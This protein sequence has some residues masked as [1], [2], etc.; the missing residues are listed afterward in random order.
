MKETHSE[1]LAPAGDLESFYAAIQYGADAV[2]LGGTAFGMRTSAA[3]FSFPTL[4]KAI[5][6]A[7]SKGVRVY[8]TCNIVPTNREAEQFPAF[9][10]SAVEA[11]ID[12]C[13]LSDLGLLLQAK[14][15]FPKLEL[16]ASTQVGIMNYQTANALYEL[17]V[18]RV[19]LARELSLDDIRFIREHTPSELELEVF[20][21][22]AMCMSV[23][24]RCLISQYLMHRDANRGACAQP[25]RWGYHLMEE[26][27][28]GQYF[29]IFED[30][31]GSYILNAKDL[32]LLPHLRKLQEAGVVSFKIEGRAK[33]SYYVAVVT[34]AYR[35][36][37]DYFAKTDDSESLPSWVVDEVFKVSHRRYN[38]GFLFGPPDD[39]QYYENGG[40][41]RNYDVVG[42]VTDYKTGYLLCEQR[43]KFCVGD[44]LEILVPKQKPIFY[45][46][47]ELL[48]ENG[49]EI[50][51]A[52][53]AKM[54]FQ[55]PYDKSLPKG[56][57]IRKSRLSAD[58]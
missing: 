55:L 28:P 1:L 43:N 5:A 35:M 40:Y 7:H 31:Q 20:V 48:D 11:G 13:I 51:S 57:F 33:S 46:V 8:L 24:G 50:E 58:N 15:L 39:G 17:G 56:S 44:E 47:T 54:L 45:T 26:K 25:C 16:H 21:H 27:R 14:K 41:L 12:A 10:E 18:K 3:S 19:V 37:L 23:S 29:P 9:L 34:N 22:G 38:T 6:Y 49:E 32:C 2:Y 30:E 53:H 36:A 4:T 52:P 42:L